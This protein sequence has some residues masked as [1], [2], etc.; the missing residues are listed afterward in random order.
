MSEPTP[1]DIIGWLQ[2]ILRRIDDIEKK[3]ASRPP[4]GPVAS[5]G[6]VAPDAD[7]DGPYGDPEL[8]FTPRDWTGE[9]HKGR[10]FSECPPDLLDL[11]ASSLDYFAAKAEKEGKT[12]ASGKPVADFNRKDAARARGWA[13]RLRQ[14]PTSP[15]TDDERLSWEGW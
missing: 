6:R 11:V 8:R 13:A 10:R 5:E 4:T 2:T 1:S 9:P 15:P 3:L 12:T 14:R 7:L